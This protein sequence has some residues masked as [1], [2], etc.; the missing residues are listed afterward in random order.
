MKT[1]YI[2]WIGLD[3]IYGP[4]MRTNC[5]Q[6]CIARES[7]NP[8]PAAKLVAVATVDLNQNGK[9]E[10]FTATPELSRKKSA[11]IRLARIHQ[12]KNT[13]YSPATV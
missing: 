13:P 12:R 10:R 7:T 9:I 11:I 2:P 8:H 5:F 4:Q 3:F 6:L 1:K